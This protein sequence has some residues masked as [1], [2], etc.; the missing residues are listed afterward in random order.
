[1]ERLNRL[2]DFYNGTFREML[3]D[4]KFDKYQFVL[5]REQLAQRIKDKWILLH[6]SD[7]PSCQN[8][9]SVESY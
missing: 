5:R 3:V 4:C 7:D 6:G 9:A 2:Q 8:G 1:M